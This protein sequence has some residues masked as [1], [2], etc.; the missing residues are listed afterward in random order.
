MAEKMTC[1]GCDSHTSSVWAAVRSGEPC[2]YCGLAASTIEA[3]NE[4][5]DARGDAALKEQ[6]A[7]A[8]V[9]AGHAKAENERLVAAMRT[10]RQAVKL[11]DEIAPR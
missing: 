7:Q 9:D 2:P 1:V 11:A 6:L 10:I 3:V 5:K 4:V 8:L